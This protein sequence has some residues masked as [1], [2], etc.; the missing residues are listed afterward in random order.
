M[1]VKFLILVVIIIIVIYFFF[2]DKHEKTSQSEYYSGNYQ[3]SSTS[4]LLLNGII[5]DNQ[6]I[7]Y[8]TWDPPSQG[9]CD[10]YKM[11][12]SGTITR[13]IDKYSQSFSTSESDPNSGRY[14]EIKDPKPDTYTITVTPSNQFGQGPQ[15]K[16]TGAIADC[17]LT[18]TKLT[19][20]DTGGGRYTAA[21]YG[22]FNEISGSGGPCGSPTDAKVSINLTDTNTGK[23][24]LKNYYMMYMETTKNISG[25]ETLQPFDLQGTKKFDILDVDIVVSFKGFTFTYNF[26]YTIGSAVPSEVKNIKIVHK[27]S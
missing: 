7:W 16:G 15:T 10:G 4:K 26:K 2:Y 8:F 5:K 21:F 3:T 24:V 9:C 23:V 18:D 12:Y 17:N 22:H 20:V 14:V 27:Y 6:S 11:T 25:W 13:T 19:M 1:C